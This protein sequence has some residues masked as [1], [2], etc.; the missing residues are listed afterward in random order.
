MTHGVE[1]PVAQSPIINIGDWRESVSVS[2]ALI[3]HQLLRIAADRES[4]KGTLQRVEARLDKKVDDH[5]ELDT[6][7][8]DKMAAAVAG[9]KD[10]VSAVDKKVT[11][12]FGGLIGV[13]SI[14]GIVFGLWALLK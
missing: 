8:F 5:S 13:Q 7:R 4:E 2:L 6:E 12:L 1:M 3:N 9:V 10:Q 11:L 14:A